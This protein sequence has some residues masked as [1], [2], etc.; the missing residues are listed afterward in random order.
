MTQFFKIT[1]VRNPVQIPFILILSWAA[2]IAVFCNSVSVTSQLM[3]PI[4]SPESM[5][6]V[7]TPSSPLLTAIAL[8]ITSIG[9]FKYFSLELASLFLNKDFSKSWEVDSETFDE[10]LIQEN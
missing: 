9:L 7:V 2:M 6:T 1:S 5:V 8:P 4:G 10:S 3:T